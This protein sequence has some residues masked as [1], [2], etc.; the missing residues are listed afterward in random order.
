MGPHDLLLHAAT[1][2][3]ADAHRHSTGI[4]ETVVAGT[5]QALAFA[6]VRSS[7]L[8]ASLSLLRDLPDL[9]SKRNVL[10]ALVRLL[11]RYARLH[12]Q[13]L[14]PSKESP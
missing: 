6:G 9:E 2:T 7:G 3:H 5:R 10:D 1:D 14:S 11:G 12:Y 4:F 8:S 13:I